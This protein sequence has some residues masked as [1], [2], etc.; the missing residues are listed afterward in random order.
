MENTIIHNDNKYASLTQLRLWSRLDKFSEYLRG[1]CGKIP[2]FSPKP[3]PYTIV[4]SSGET[5]PSCYPLP[6]GLTV[7]NRAKR[8]DIITRKLK[9]NDSMNRTFHRL[10]TQSFKIKIETEAFLLTTS[11]ES[12]EDW[13]WRMIC[14]IT[15]EVRKEL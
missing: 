2:L 10:R 7:W 3:R 13:Y 5:Y 8:Q 14:W 4:E 6:S 9:P 11:S 12:R 1:F 15:Y